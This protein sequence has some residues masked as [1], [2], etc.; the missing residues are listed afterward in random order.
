MWICQNWSHQG[1]TNSSVSSRIQ[2][3]LSKSSFSRTEFLILERR[4]W[5][6]FDPVEVALTAL[7]VNI[8]RGNSEVLNNWNRNIDKSTKVIYNCVLGLDLQGFR[9]NNN[10]PQDQA[11]YLEL[12]YSWKIVS[13]FYVFFRVL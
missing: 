6:W 11:K 4:T 7:I 12:S 9:G 1:I 10:H 13:E 2:Q 3:E 5:L 8:W